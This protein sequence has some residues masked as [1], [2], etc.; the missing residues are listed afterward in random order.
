MTKIIKV[1]VSPKGETKLETVGFSGSECQNASRDFERALGVSTGEQLT[2][3]Y[4]TE[5]NE[6]QVGA[7]N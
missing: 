6:Q 5:S 7:Q 1:T 2:S 4:Y 3:E